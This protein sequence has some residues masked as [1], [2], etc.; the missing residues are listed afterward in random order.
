MRVWTDIG[1]VHIK[2]IRMDKQDTK[3]DKSTGHETC[4]YVYMTK[5]ALSAAALSASDGGA[6]SAA[7][8][9]GAPEKRLD[10]RLLALL[11]MRKLRFIVDDRRSLPGG[12][13]P[14][15][16][17]VKASNSVVRRCSQKCTV[18]IRS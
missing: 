9:A 7:L 11:R 12:S 16:L 1:D 15:R 2:N 10:L 6:A 5:Q 14:R 4:S 17:L 13:E 8:E 3:G 18:P